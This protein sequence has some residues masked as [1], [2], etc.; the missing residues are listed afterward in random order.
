MIRRQQIPAEFP[1]SGI[2]ITDVDDVAFGVADLDA[3]ADSIRCAGQDI[4]STQKTGDWR[5]H[6]QSENQ[7][8]HS[9]RN[10]RG[11]PILKLDRND[12]DYQQ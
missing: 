5:L 3:I 4:D 6:R 2:Q 7:R 8:K 9:D 1:Q 11:I 10:E 12:R